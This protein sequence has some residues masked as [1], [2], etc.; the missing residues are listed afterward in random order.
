[1]SMYYDNQC[2]I[3]IA[4]NPMFHDCIKHIVVD[5]HFARDYFVKGVICT[6]LTLSSEQLDDILIKATL[7][8][9]FSIFCDKLLIIDI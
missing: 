4:H 2:T 5:C 8:N 6:V 1:M 9:V 3:Y 7:P